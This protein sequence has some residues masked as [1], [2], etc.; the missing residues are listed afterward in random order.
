MKKTIYIFMFFSLLLFF[1]CGQGE[2]PKTKTQSETPVTSIDSEEQKI[3]Y[4]MGYNMG[5]NFRQIYPNLDIDSLIQGIIDSINQK[6]SL[7]TND[8][9]QK[10]LMQLQE[11]MRKSQQVQKKAKA[12]ENK[13][14]G[15]KFLK[16]NAKK[17]GIKVTKSG[18]Q[19]QIIKPG[20]GPQP[21]VNDTV[22]V[23]YRGTFIDGNEFD[24]SYKRGV[25]ASFPLNRVISGW[26][27]GLQLMKVGSKY[28]FFIP[29]ELA[30]KEHGAPPTIGPNVTLIFEVELLEIIKFDKQK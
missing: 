30:Y 3:S 9:I 15:E 1:S 16:E 19:Y 22:K 18:L 13:I 14:E 23:N 27:E 4:A 21:K 20:N 29:S 17:K 10:T 24:S 12:E 8:E 11:N 26:T 7:M 5:N 2:K 28:K 25:P 6:E